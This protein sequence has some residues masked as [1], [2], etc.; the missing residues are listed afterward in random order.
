M[1]GC[2]KFVTYHLPF[3]L[4]FKSETG[5]IASEYENHFKK[6]FAHSLPKLVSHNMLNTQTNK[7]G[8]PR[9]LKIDKAIAPFLNCTSMTSHRFHPQP[10][11]NNYL[12]TS[13][14]KQFF[15]VKLLLKFWMAWKKMAQS[16]NLSLLKT[17]TYTRL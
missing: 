7:Y 13:F 11:S 15:S 5:F 16:T 4:A 17:W 14:L 12:H 3:I 9:A 1:D 6:Y 10:Q 2:N 8:F